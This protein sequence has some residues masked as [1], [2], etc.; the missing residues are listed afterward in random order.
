MVSRSVLYIYSQPRFGLSRTINPLFIFIP[1]PNADPVV[2][3][4]CDMMIGALFIFLSFFLFF[5]EP[6]ATYDHKRHATT[7]WFM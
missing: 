5:P 2:I 6:R 7:R 1:I 4:L 3:S